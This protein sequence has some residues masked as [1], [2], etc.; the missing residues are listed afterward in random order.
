VIVLAE[1]KDVQPGCGGRHPLPALHALTRD[2]PEITKATA[3]TKNYS[4]S[5]WRR[6]LIE[7]ISPAHD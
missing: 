6:R 5:G 2:T 1:F 7:S 4:A 3:N